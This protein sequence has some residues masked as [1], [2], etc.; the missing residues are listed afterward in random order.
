MKKSISIWEQKWLFEWQKLLEKKEKEIIWRK[1]L[2]K[3]W[4][5]TDEIWSLFCKNNKNFENIP[6]YE[7]VENLIIEQ[8]ILIIKKAKRH[9]LEYIKIDWLSY[10]RF[11]IYCELENHLVVR[12]GFEENNFRKNIHD[13]YFN[14]ISQFLQS[15]RDFITFTLERT[16]FEIWSI[17]DRETS[18]NL[19][20][21]DGLSSE[22]SPVDEEK[23]EIDHIDPMEFGWRSII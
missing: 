3:F 14:A 11:N 15:E 10:D 19:P 7:K 8:F 1:I 13:L 18:S 9:W 23:C 6:N 16:S 22:Q 12:Y 21:N 17:L 5:L 20:E 4:E 2:W